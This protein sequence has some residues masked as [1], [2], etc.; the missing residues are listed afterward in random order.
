MDNNNNKQFQMS[1]VL[2]R[3][4]NSGIIMSIE[5]NE[6][7]ITGLEKILANITTLPYVSV[8][9]SYTG[10]LHGA[11]HGKNIGYGDSVT[12]SNPTNKEEKF[13]KWLGISNLK[14]KE[15]DVFERLSVNWENIGDFDKNFITQSTLVVDL[16][17]LGFGP[18]AAL[19]T[20]EREVWE[21]A[22]R[23][24][25][26]G[27][28]DLRTMWTQEESHPDL[29]PGIQFNYRISPL[30]AACTKLSLIKRGVAVEN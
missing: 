6:K 28:F 20:D 22:E 13:L 25:I 30:V 5:K 1:F 29:Q 11:L 17:D 2:L 24:K 21:K 10:A 16:T 18:C 19:A 27:A 4:L 7:E 23:L 8:F 9:N 15:T 12:L 14:D 3:V 26:F